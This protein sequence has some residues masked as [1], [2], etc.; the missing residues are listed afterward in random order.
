MAKYNGKYRNTQYGI[1]IIPRDEFFQENTIFLGDKRYNIFNHTQDQ[2]VNIAINLSLIIF[3][4]DALNYTNRIRSQTNKSKV[5]DTLKRKVRNNFDRKC[6]ICNEAPC[7]ITIHHTQPAYRGGSNL[8]ENLLPL[9]KNHHQ[10][11][12]ELSANIINF[13][14][15][16]IHHLDEKFEILYQRFLKVI[17][18]CSQIFFLNESPYKFYILDYENYLINILKGEQ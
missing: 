7:K 14:T 5:C 18:F 8:E 13:F 11:L 16:M 12:H 3:T 9:C 17:A 1:S 4:F 2:S 6:I 10:R 15:K